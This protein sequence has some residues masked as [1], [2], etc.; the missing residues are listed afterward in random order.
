ML[1]QHRHER[2]ARQRDQYRRER[3]SHAPP[4]AS[5][6]SGALRLPRDPTR[7]LRLWRVQD[8]NGDW[9]CHLQS[10]HEYSS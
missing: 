4:G 8:L 9:Y 6:G 3:D 7:F 5:I 2:H 1:L 10:C